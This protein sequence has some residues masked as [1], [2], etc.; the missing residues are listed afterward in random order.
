MFDFRGTLRDLSHIRERDGV[1]WQ[2][3]LDWEMV[4]KEWRERWKSHLSA[5][6]RS[7]LHFAP[8]RWEMMAQDAKWWG[9]DTVWDFS[10]ISNN[11]L[12]SGAARCQVITFLRWKWTILWHKQ[13]WVSRQPGLTIRHPHQGI[14]REDLHHHPHDPPKTEHPPQRPGS[15][16]FHRPHDPHPPRTNN[17]L[18]HC[19]SA[20][21]IVSLWRESPELHSVKWQMVRPPRAGRTSRLHRGASGRSPALLPFPRRHHGKLQRATFSASLNTSLVPPC[22]PTAATD[23]CAH[24]SALADCL[25]VF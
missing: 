23:A 17:S 25:S 22:T 15:V 6:G 8:D 11:D 12:F 18:I 2:K 20:D 16:R 10:T 13:R 7:T 3:H 9:I 14:S 1:Y 5:G 19:T 21:L 24:I 4:K